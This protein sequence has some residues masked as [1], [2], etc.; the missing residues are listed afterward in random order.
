MKVEFYQPY[1][2]RVPLVIPRDTPEAV[3]ERALERIRRAKRIKA[4][5]ALS[6][7]RSLYALGRVA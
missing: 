1:C 7:S 2:Y 5:V 4:N 6:P 3:A